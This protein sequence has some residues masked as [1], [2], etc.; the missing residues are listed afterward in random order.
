MRTLPRASAR[1]PGSP[2]RHAQ[3]G[4][5]PLETLH[6]QA[7]ANASDHTHLHDGRIAARLPETCAACAL[8]HQLLWT[9]LVL[10][11]WHVGRMPVMRACS[12]TACSRVKGCFENGAR[13]QAWLCGG[14]RRSSGLALQSAEQRCRCCRTHSMLAGSSLICRGQSTRACLRAGRAV[15][16]FVYIWS[17]GCW[18]FGK[19]LK[20]RSPPCASP[21]CQPLKHR[22]AVLRTEVYTS[23]AM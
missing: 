1:S 9:D 12:R 7:L 15:R 4:C 22:S 2:C 18:V 21:C 19:R 14:P 17:V 10:S 20:L 13:L 8:P 23:G 5:G 3:A 6:A 11:C 16:T